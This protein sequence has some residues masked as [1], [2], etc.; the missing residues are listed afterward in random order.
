MGGAW[1]RESASF[2]GRAC[3][4]VVRDGEGQERASRLLL[5]STYQYRVRATGA[6]KRE[7]A[8]GVS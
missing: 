6:M 5:A 8:P 7:L 1:G 3:G 2:R 4:G